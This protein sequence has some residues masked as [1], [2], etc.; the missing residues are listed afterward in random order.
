METESLHSYLN[1]SQRQQRT[2]T[3]SR[4]ALA[5]AQQ[6]NPA[7]PKR[8]FDRIE[9]LFGAPNRRKMLITCNEVSG[10]GL[11]HWP[12]RWCTVGG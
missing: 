7:L 5:G 12:V 10:Q 1:S 3:A 2:L 8:S 9:V 4:A 11:E 6:V